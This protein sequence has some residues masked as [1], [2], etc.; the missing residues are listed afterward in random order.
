[1]RRRRVPCLIDMA[2]RAAVL[3]RLRSLSVGRLTV[4]DYA[5]RHEFGDPRETELHATVT[6]HHGSAY[7]QVATGGSL[8][9]AEGYLQ[10]AW[11]C[12][13]LVKLFRLLAINAPTLH[14]LNGRWARLATPFRW[15]SDYWRRNT[16]AASRRYIAAHY[17]L[18]NEFFSL[19]LDESMTYSSGIF[20][21][22]VSTLAEASAAKYERICRKLRIGPRDHVL[23]I[24]T[25]W[26]GFAM[27]A[28][29]E[30]GCRVTTTT[31][32][33]QQYDFVR[34]RIERA[35]L[36]DHITLLLEDYRDLR[37]TYDKIVSIEMI[38]AVGHEYLATYFDKC[39]ELL[40][41]DGLFALQAITMPERDYRRYR[42][43]TDFIRKYIFPGGCLP[44]IA[45]ISNSAG[46]TTGLQFTELRDFSEDYAR[47]LAMW[48]DNFFANLSAVRQLGFD[49]RFIRI[50]EY[51]LCYCEA[52]FREAKIGLAQILFRKA[53]A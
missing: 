29:R 6:I 33:R 43:T 25:G 52:G 16:R 38:E 2:A 40:R 18:S 14:R 39:C 9:A 50:W 49:E 22:G 7:R 30:Y 36:A 48:R 35:G 28:A 20:A 10:H 51:Y 41:P 17:D 13:D 11:S 42:A 31:I 1:M 37:G 12:D 21:D 53:H 24:G 26:G 5:G 45:A 34:E 15:L 23:E 46:A 32:S 8:D 3:R 4:V 27:Y 19:F 44:S 47:T